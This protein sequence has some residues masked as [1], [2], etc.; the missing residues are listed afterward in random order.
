M[1]NKY[2]VI[3]IGA[4]L[5]GLTAAALL[6]K[7]GRKVL[8][9]EKNP[10]AGGY[11]VNFRRGEFN[12][13]ASLHLLDGFGENGIAY[14]ILKECNILDKIKL[15]KPKYLYRSI[16]PDFDISVPQTNV[17]LYM[18]ILSSY[19]P[20][21]SRNIANLMKVM[22]QIA[23]E[24][25]GFLYSSLPPNLERIVSLFR[26]PHLVSC[27]TKTFQNILDGFLKEHR[28]KAIMSQL[29]PYF[30]LP[31]SKL[32]SCYYAFP[33]WDYLTMGG[34]YPEGGSE[35]LTGAFLSTL[36]EYGGE[37]RLFTG[38]RKIIIKNKCAKGVL[39]E[40]DEFL[41]AD[42]FIS[43]V[44]ARSTFLNLIGK[45]FLPKQYIRTIEMMQPSVSIFQIYMGLNCDLKD[46]G[47][48]DYEIFYNPNY[49]MDRQYFAISDYSKAEEWFF[50]IA[51]HSNINPG[52]CP[53]G[54]SILSI[55]VLSDYDSWAKFSR[56][57]YVKH[58]KIC[59]FNIVKQA[60]KIIPGL[61]S[62]IERMEEATPLTME[63]YTGS[64]KGAVYGW[65]QIVSQG[66]I[67][68]LRNVTPIKNLYLSGAWT[69][70]GGGI[71]MV[72]VS[73]ALAARSILNNI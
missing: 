61:S 8:V 7:N 43:N 12:F 48:N 63:R 40:K 58:K 33:V 13:E 26:Y 41:E 20:S 4:G 34:Y 49:D 22:K 9:L 14:G 15:L 28:L 65:S 1:T 62:Y 68:R 56:N 46:K 67:N 18:E 55:T 53:R 35:K 37:V 66:G 70:M 54:K 47:Y 44:D 3:V 23:E 16:Y 11:A 50:C 39:T 29:W 72:T 36:R 59:A 31:P 71:S 69:R 32:A 45:Q 25:T 19:F 51:I 5:G 52:I 24:T 73:G 27:S 2:D 21:E 57:E 17:N 42:Y 10:V 6:A 64:Y 60:E 38:A 30:G